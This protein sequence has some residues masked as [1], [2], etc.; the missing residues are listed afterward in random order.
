M[1]FLVNNVDYDQKKSENGGTS[2]MST[3]NILIVSLPTSPKRIIRP[4]K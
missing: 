4:A 3:I 1:K 2:A